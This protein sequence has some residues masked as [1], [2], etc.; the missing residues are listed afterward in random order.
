MASLSLLVFQYSDTELFSGYLP[1]IYCLARP[2]IFI[3][4]PTVILCWKKPCCIVF[5]VKIQYTH[6]RDALEP[7]CKYRRLRR[8]EDQILCVKCLK[9]IN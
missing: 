4:Y 8:I 3:P 9:N 1:G 6:Q 5:M 7:Y 2:P